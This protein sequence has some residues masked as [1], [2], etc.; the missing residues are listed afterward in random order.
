MG[1]IQK[2]LGI[3]SHTAKGTKRCLFLE[4]T[5]FP[6]FQTEQTFF[7][8]CR[9]SGQA[10]MVLPFAQFWSVCGRGYKAKA[11]SGGMRLLCSRCFVDMPMSFQMT[12]PGGMNSENIT[13]FGEGLPSNLFDSSKA[14]KCPYCGVDS[15]I[16]LWDAPNYGEI[17]EEDMQALRELWE[18]RCQLW[19]KQNDRTEGICDRCSNARIPR[20]Q[21]YHRGSDVICEK[22]AMEATNDKA[23]SETRN[24]PDYWGTS[25]LRRARNLRLG[26]WRFE[27][28]RFSV[29]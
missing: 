19:W 2:F 11:I 27:R 23:L 5:K 10:A 29:T 28:G 8:E 14:A 13:A 26:K 3:F 17:T 22:C 7:N 1:L 12:L 4:G 15:G 6:V 20:G 21:G 24:N 9:E 16:L 18:F 25:E